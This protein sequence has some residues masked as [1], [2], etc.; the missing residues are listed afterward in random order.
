MYPGRRQQARA[1]LE[2]IEVGERG[3]GQAESS[4]RQ[5]ERRRLFP[6]PTEAALGAAHDRIEDAA[7]A[8]EEAAARQAIA[9]DLRRQALTAY[10]A[11]AEAWRAALIAN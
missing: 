3:F 8:R 10:R 6:G 11:A 7:A 5:R 2:A 4:R 9:E 1:E